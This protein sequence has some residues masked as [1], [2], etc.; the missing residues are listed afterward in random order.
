MNYQDRNVGEMKLEP[1]APLWLVQLATSLQNV[2]RSEYLAHIKTFNERVASDG[3]GRAI[4]Q[5]RSL[6]SQYQLEQSDIF[7]DARSKAVA[8][9]Y[10]DA[11]TGLTWSG[12]GRAPA[13]LDGKDRAAFAI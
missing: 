6:V 10:R 3:R 1:G 4:E 8:P 5:A 2:D 7:K 9:K 11:A 13:W 12:R